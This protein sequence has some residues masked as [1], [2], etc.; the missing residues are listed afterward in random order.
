MTIEIFD[1]IIDEMIDDWMEFGTKGYNQI[2]NGQSIRSAS[3]PKIQDIIIAIIIINQDI[4]AFAIV[5]MNRARAR[6]R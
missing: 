6:I 4:I 5:E 2:E 3:P 1:E